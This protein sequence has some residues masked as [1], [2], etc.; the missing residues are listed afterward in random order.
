MHVVTAFAVGHSITLA[1]GA[2]GYV[3]V[4]TRVVESLIAL[5]ILVSGVHAVR[6]LARGGEVW[7]AGGFGLMHGL[8]F[9]ALLGGLDLGRGSL[10]TALLG[11]NLGIELTQLLVVALVMPSLA[12][13]SRTR[14]YPAVRIVLAGSG[15][16]LAA[17]WLAE[18]TT[19][20][21]ANPVEEVSAALVA[22]PMSA[23]AVLAVL[24]AAARAVTPQR[25]APC[26]P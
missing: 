19:L 21:S 14:L 17:F 24:A 10:V 6:P 23:A 12:V 26:P 20:I 1:L 11:F 5:S 22:H 2:L 8:A 7:I 9:A 13:L 4:P 15:C 18:R 3:A 16:V 25:T